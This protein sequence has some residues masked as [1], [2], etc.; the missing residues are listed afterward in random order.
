M[1]RWFPRPEHKRGINWS[2]VAGFIGAL[3]VAA[4]Y[5]YDDLQRMLHPHVYFANVFGG[6]VIAF[7]WAGWIARALVALI[8]A[9]RF[10]VGKG[11][12]WG[13]VVLVAFLVPLLAY[14]AFGR[15][16]P[17]IALTVLRFVAG[18]ALM[19]GIRGAWLTRSIE[20][21]PDYGQVFQ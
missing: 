11:L 19:I 10:A 21:E 2:L 7:L 17:S 14:L 13:L 4:A 6:R 8:A 9:W 15:A 5:L 18:A 16:D 1:P 3:I 20:P 12:V